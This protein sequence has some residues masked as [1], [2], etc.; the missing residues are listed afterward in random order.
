MNKY[1]EKQKE[2][3]LSVLEE[4]AED[5]VFLKAVNA[6]AYALIQLTKEDKR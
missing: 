3:L 4:Y 6:L 1:N 5:V 2:L